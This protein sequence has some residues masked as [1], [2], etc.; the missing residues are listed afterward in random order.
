MICTINAPKNAKPNPIN[1]SDV[2]SIEN[3]VIIAHGD[4]TNKTNAEIILLSG[5]L[6]VFV[7]TKRY[8]KKIIINN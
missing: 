1:L 6:R 2:N 3:D 5:D 4:A 8:P 7:F